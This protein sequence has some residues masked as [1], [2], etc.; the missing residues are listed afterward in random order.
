[1]ELYKCKPFCMGA[2]SLDLWRFVNGYF[3]MKDKTTPHKCPNHITSEVL[4][5]NVPI[6]DKG[7]CDL[8]HMNATVTAE[9]AD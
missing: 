6:I 9:K 1:M 2:Y 3:P 5:P 8:L 7:R 4:Q